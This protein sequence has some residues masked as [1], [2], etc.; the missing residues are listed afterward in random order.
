MERNNGVTAIIYLA[1]VR[2]RT[3]RPYFRSANTDTIFH[4]LTISPSPKLQVSF[5]HPFQP[6]HKP[7]A[8]GL[9][10]LV[11]LLEKKQK[12]REEKW[13]GGGKTILEIPKR[14]NPKCWD[15]LLRVSGYRK[16]FDTGPAGG[17]NFPS[18][19]RA[20]SQ[21]PSSGPEQTGALMWQ[22]ATIRALLN[23]TLQPTAC[24]TRRFIRWVIPSEL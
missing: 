16:G 1:L 3:L 5:K 23:M 9:S 21:F 12:R 14:G 20:F 10:F 4:S 6:G 13:R 22:Q 15:L 8:T 7:L 17:C 19:P 18:R 24:L 2:N 11:D